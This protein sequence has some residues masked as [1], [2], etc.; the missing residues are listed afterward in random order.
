MHNSGVLIILSGT[1][2]LLFVKEDSIIDFHNRNL[3]NRVTTDLLLLTDFFATPK[4]IWLS[5]NRLL[6]EPT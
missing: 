6:T 3:F 5:G 2:L 4:D 1:K